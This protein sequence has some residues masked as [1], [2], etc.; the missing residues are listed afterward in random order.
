MAWTYRPKHTDHSSKYGLQP[1]QFEKDIETHKKEREERK[2]RYKGTL[3]TLLTETTYH[4]ENFHMLVQV[5]RELKEDF[6]V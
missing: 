5:M 2:E 4:D 3:R 6:A 1:N